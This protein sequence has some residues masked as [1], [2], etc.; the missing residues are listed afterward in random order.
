[1]GVVSQ[2]KTGK[3]IKH[4]YIGVSIIPDPTEKQLKELGLEKKRGLLIH[5]VELGSPAFKAGLAAYDFITRI[6]G[7]KAK[8]FSDLK[9]AVL[10]KKIGDEIVLKIIRRAKRQTIKV[11]VHEKNS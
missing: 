2:W 4:G 8:K 9:T 1:M 6:D 11:K 5:S 3:K 10:R 7:K